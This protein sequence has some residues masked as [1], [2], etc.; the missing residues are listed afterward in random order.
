MNDETEAGRTMSMPTTTIDRGTGN[1]RS[2]LSVDCHDETRARMR[3][4]SSHGSRCPAN[5]SNRGAQNRSLFIP[6]IAAIIGMTLSLLSPSAAE[7]RVATGG[8]GIYRSR[9]FWLEWPATIPSGTVATGDI[10]IN[11]NVVRVTCTLTVNTGAVSGYEPGSFSGDGLDDLYNIDGT[12]TANSMRSGIATTAANATVTITCSAL[13]NPGTAEQEVYPLPGIVVAEAETNGGAFEYLE[14][15]ITGNFTVTERFRTCTARR[16]QA[17]V[18]AAGATETVRFSNPDNTCAT[19]TAGTTGPMGI[20]FGRFGSTAYSGTNMQVAI[21]LTIATSTARSAVAVGIVLDA[22]QKD[23]PAS[24]GDVTHLE[25]VIF[26]PDNLATGTTN[27]IFAIASLATPSLLPTP[28]LGSLIDG[29]GLVGLAPSVGA[30]TD[31]TTTTDDEDAFGTIPAVN[32]A[33]ATYAL[34]VPY[35]QAVAGTRVCGWIDFNR[36]GLFTDNGAEESCVTV[37]TGSGNAALSWTLPAGNAY[38]AGNSYARF[39]IG[40]NAAGSPTGG[41]VTGEVEDHTVTLNPRLRVNKTLSPTTDG[42]LFNLTVNPAP[43]ATFTASNQG[44][45]G[46]TG[47]QTIPMGSAVTLSETAGTATNLAAYTP[48]LTCTNR[49]GATVIGPVAVTSQSYTFNSA[50]TSGATS[51]TPATA[52]NI[53]DTEL[54]C[55]FTN[56]LNTNLS[57]TKTNTPANGPSDQPNDNV[58]R[59]STTYQL[60]VTNHGLMPVTEALVREAPQAGITCPGANNV[61]IDYSGATPDAN[62]TVAV[63]TSTG[64][65]LGTLGASETATLTFSCTVD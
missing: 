21:D 24:Y 50:S 46:T 31:D 34:N 8:T 39:R 15:K 45:D 1:I 37:A 49:V 25:D 63:L 30:S 17:V 27:D 10:I 48:S 35:I 62:S 33:A 26:A 9:I 36:D 22:D 16:T 58:A 54:T 5:T 3:A 23:A 47:L 57:I 51:N 28:T 64:L 7:A 56:S 38:V 59:G 4:A 60:I 43:T 18:T 40:A 65:T 41:T 6:T 53:S 12:G 29:D 52:A 20:S 13:A 44:N 14:A 11:G 61:A 42:G 19:Q 55:V 32:G 2:S